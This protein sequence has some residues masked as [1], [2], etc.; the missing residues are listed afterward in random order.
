VGK[1]GIE[2][3]F[4]R[5]VEDLLEMLMVEMSEYPE[6]MF[7]DVFGGVSEGRREIAA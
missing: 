6:K 1:E 5:Q 2:V 7:V 3:S 4:D